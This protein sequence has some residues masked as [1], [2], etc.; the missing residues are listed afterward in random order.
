MT[1]IGEIALFYV[2]ISQKLR[3]LKASATYSYFNRHSV[4]QINE[5]D[6]LPDSGNLIEFQKIEFGHS[7]DV[8]WL[9]VRNLRYRNRS[10]FSYREIPF[11]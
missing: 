2:A 4:L 11:G 3:I 6:L 1:V 8:K 7:Y 10:I 5:Q 9:A